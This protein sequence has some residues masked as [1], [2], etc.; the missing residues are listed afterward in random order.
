MLFRNFLHLDFI[1]KNIMNIGLLYS[2][3]DDL[4]VSA[5]MSLFLLVIMSADL[6]CI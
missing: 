6:V 4:H 3:L 2:V 5:L 1:S